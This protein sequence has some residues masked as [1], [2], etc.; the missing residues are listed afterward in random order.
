MLSMGVPMVLLIVFVKNF[1]CTVKSSA[2]RIIHQAHDQ[3]LSSLIFS[4][5]EW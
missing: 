2:A 4:S 5:I 1:K 3:V